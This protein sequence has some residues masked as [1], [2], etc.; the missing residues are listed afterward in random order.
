MSPRSNSSQPISAFVDAGFKKTIAALMQEVVDLYTSDDMPWV[1]GYSGGKDSTAVLQLVWIAL[2]Q[3]PQEKRS[4]PV[5]VISTDTLVEN[6]IVALWVS[7]SLEKMGAAA[8]RRNLPL[9]AHRLTPETENTF[10]VNLIGRGYPAP[11]PKFRWCTERLKIMPSTRFIN[12]VVQ[13]HGEAILVLGSRKVESAARARVMKRFEKQRVRD[14]LSPNGNLPNSFVYTPVEE[15]TNDDVWLY[16][17]QVSNPWGYN[18]K[19]LLTMYQGAS[20]DGECPLV[21]DTSTPSCGDSRF[22]CWV[23]TLVDK[24]KSMQAMIQNDEEKEWMLPLL[25]LRNEL[26]P[27]KTPDADRPLRDFRRMSGIVQLYRDRP[28]PGPYKQEVREN[29]LRKVLRVQ[30]HIRANG[31]EEVRDIVLITIE[32]LQE[33]RRIWVIEKHEIED[34][35][36][37]VY[38]ETMGEPYPGSRIDDNLVLG[39][40]QMDLLRQLCGDDMLHFQLTRELLSIE[41]QHKSMLR[42]VGLFK[43]IDRA[44]HRNFY[45]DEDDALIRVRKRRS[46]LDLAKERV[47][48][49]TT[50][51]VQKILDVSSQDEVTK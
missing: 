1:I 51:E 31:P 41:K 47:F 5:Y 42:R 16:L 4:K 43:A 29:W 21:V 2:E 38:E 30:Q 6:P 26:D 44:F 22:G 3:V 11:R 35:L 20:E 28:I 12:S 32:E 37:N 50:P 18:N 25:Q 48:E 23:C 15:W 8:E 13:E 27:P 46:A 17:M 14:R 19:D 7:K 24:D 40:P 36:P 34:S 45:D 9:T 49:Q 33:I 10:W 39:G